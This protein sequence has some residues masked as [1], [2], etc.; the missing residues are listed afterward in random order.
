MGAGGSLLVF[1]LKM[2]LLYLFI[3]LIYSLSNSKFTLEWQTGSHNSASNARIMQKPKFSLSKSWMEVK[4][5][6]CTCSEE[7]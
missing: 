3:L 6:H 5:G 4:Q 2:C 7:V 1:L